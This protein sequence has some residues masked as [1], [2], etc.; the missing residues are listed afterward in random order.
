[1]IIFIRKISKKDNFLGDSVEGQGWGS[2]V[3]GPQRGLFS[4]LLC[5]LALYVHTLWVTHSCCHEIGR[6]VATRGFWGRR[7]LALWRS[8]QQFSLFLLLKIVRQDREVIC[9]RRTKTEGDQVLPMKISHSC[10]SNC[11]LK[12]SNVLVAML[13]DEHFEH[14]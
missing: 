4:Y 5:L 7:S 14:A 10:L 6:R 3:W 1:M 2:R 9:N 11:P 13:V 8:S 12:N